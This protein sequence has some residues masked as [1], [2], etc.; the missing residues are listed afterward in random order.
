VNIETDE[1]AMVEVVRVGQEARF[2]EMLVDKLDHNTRFYFYSFGVNRWLG[3]RLEAVG[4]LMVLIASLG[5]LAWQ[6]IAVLYLNQEGGAASSSWIAL[7]I[8][9]TLSISG[10]LNWMV[11]Q[12]SELEVQMNAVERICEFA[13]DIPS[14]ED[15]KYLDWQL[16]HQMQGDFVSRRL[17]KRL[18]RMKSVPLSLHDLWTKMSTFNEINFRLPSRHWRKLVNSTSSLYQME[19]DS[20][21]LFEPELAWPEHGSISASDMRI[22]YRAGLSPVLDHISFHIRAGERIGIVGRTGA[23][24]SSFTLALFRLVQLERG[25]NDVRKP[26]LTIDG[27]DIGT[28]PLSRLRSILGIIPQDPVIFSGSMR[29]NLDPSGEAFSDHD[30]WLALEKVGLKVWVQSLGGLDADLSGSDGGK[31]GK[32]DES[33]GESCLS[34]GQRQLLCLA[35]ALLRKP[36]ILVM[37]EATASL[38][39]GADAHIKKFI[40]SEFTQKTQDGEEKRVT[41][42]TIAHRLDTILDSDRI[43]VFDAGR[44]VEFDTPSELLRKGPDGYLAGLVKSEEASRQAAHMQS[45]FE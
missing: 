12:L 28:L 37:D 23:G 5:S 6:V 8:T 32:E 16:R 36:K 15:P 17:S 27:V 29:F 40:R 3:T 11:R 24:K 7:A 25:G 14:E 26:V 31:D 4:A 38:D 39:Y 19:E 35:R 34:V 9:S 18:R 42:L 13:D 33:K 21:P 41:I 44:L 20:S 1:I 30:L 45:V 2:L 22:R 43:M 10:N